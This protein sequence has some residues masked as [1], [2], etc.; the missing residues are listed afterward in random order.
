[1][2]ITDIIT[3]LNLKVISGHSGLANDITGG[4]VSDLLS[5]VMGN[6]K[7][8][9]IWITLQTHQNIIA[10]A[11]LKDISAIII[12]KGNVPEPDTIEKSNMENI[13]VLSTKLD[14]FNIAGR[15]FELLKE[16]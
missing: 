7:E 1:M 16:G 11:S 10:V 13:P 8:G 14:T 15:V 6:A 2:K 3:R 12:V 9:Q 5:D 4:Y